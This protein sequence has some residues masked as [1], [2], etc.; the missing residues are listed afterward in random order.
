M[1][2]SQLYRFLLLC[3]EGQFAEKDPEEEELRNIY[4][5]DGFLDEKKK[6]EEEI[7]KVEKKVKQPVENGEDLYLEQIYSNFETKS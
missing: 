5:F 2:L 4:D 6:K 3:G 7:T 1:D